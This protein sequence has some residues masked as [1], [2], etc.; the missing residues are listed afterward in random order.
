MRGD[1]VAPLG[2]ILGG[3][4]VTRGSIP[5]GDSTPGLYSHAPLGLNRKTDMV[6]FS[7]KGA[8]VHSQG[9]HP[10][11]NDQKKH[12]SPNGATETE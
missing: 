9:I 8:A 10:L 12:P 5:F 11:V 3:R 4:L 1:S 7:P 6:T 2:L